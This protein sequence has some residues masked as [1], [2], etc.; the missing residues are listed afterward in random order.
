MLADDEEIRAFVA[1][2]IAAFKVPTRIAFTN[3]RLPRNPAGKFLKRDLRTRF[4][5]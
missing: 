4:F 5:V 2:R 3:E 1:A